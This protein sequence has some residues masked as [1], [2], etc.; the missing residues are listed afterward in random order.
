MLGQSF[1]SRKGQGQDSNVGSG[2]HNH[3]PTRAISCLKREQSLGHEGEAAGLP[4][5]P[6][7]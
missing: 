1:T 2:C 5:P 4:L 3:N 6:V 7:P